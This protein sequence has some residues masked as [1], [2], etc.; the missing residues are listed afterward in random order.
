MSKRTLG[1]QKVARNRGA[2][3]RTKLRQGKFESKFNPTGVQLAR[4]KSTLSQEAVAKRAGIS[5]ATYGSIE[6]AKRYVSVDRASEI[7]KILGTQPERLFRRVSKKKMV[8]INSG[9]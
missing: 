3:W 9:D 6:R 7:A 8:A 4:H 5:I 1:N 2:E